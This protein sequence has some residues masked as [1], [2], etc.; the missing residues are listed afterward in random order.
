MSELSGVIVVTG[1]GGAIGRATA[2]LLAERGAHV[3]AVDLVREAAQATAEKVRAMGGSA[4]PLTA[5]VTDPGQVADYARTATE[6][7]T[8]TGFVNNA[9]IEG[10]V[11]PIGA[12]SVE[13][14]DAV[15]AVNLR[16]VFLGLSAMLPL[17]SRGGAVVN[18]ASIGG[19]RGSPG[20]AAYV[21]SKHAVVGLTRV[22]ALEVAERGVRV[23]AV[24][25]SAVDSRMMTSLDD[26]RSAAG[27]A[28]SAGNRSGR[29][30][31]PED[32]AG[33]IGYLLGPHSAFVNGTALAVDGSA[34]AG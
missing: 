7:G 8:V 6:L 9:G 18:T 26:Q 21:A 28:P 25:P 27:L 4:T 15:L 17:L 11:A 13:S 34:T 24:C 19:L 33:A 22:A 5:D 10:T 23:N 1:A 2:L 29:R 32:V 16:G 3:L 20:M 12:M 30:A 31:T 14:F